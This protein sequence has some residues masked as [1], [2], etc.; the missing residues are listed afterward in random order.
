MKIGITGTREGMND[1]QRRMIICRFEL[2][3]RDTPELIHEIHH[4]DCVGVDVQ[5]AEIAKS[6]GHKIVCHPPI[7][8]EMRGY[9]ASDETRPPYGYLQRD[10]NIVDETEFLIVV[11]K[12]NER[13]LTSGTWYTHD[14]AKGKSKDLVIIFPDP[15]DEDD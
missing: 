2:M 5:V 12:E 3:A 11:P 8:H 13:Q 1:H 9:F 14:Y 7:K 15:P 4:G 10:R 6:F